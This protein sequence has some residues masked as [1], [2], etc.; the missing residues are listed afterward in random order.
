MTIATDRDKVRLLIGD[1]DST[2]PQLYDDEIAFFLAA[3][4]ARGFEF[5]D[6]E[7]RTFKPGERVEHYTKLA[8]RLRTRASGGV[9]VIQTTR[10]DG[11]SED[12]SSRDGAGQA[13]ST[14]RVRA[15]YFNPDLP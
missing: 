4:Y 12:I 2:K 7:R 3:K 8:Q 13:S 6:G 1:T 9:S 10:V 15:G 5:S 14:G 11:Y